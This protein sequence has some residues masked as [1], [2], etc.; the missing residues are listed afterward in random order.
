MTAPKTQ[1]M[2]ERPIGIFDSGLGG[3]SVWREI[4]RQ[5]P[6]ESTIYF[7][8]SAR[9][10]YGPKTPEQV[11]DYSFEITERLLDLGCKAI[12]VACN[13]ATAAAIE[14]LRNSFD[15]PFIGMEPAVKPAALRT[16]TGHVGVLATQGTLKG[17]LYRKTSQKYANDV[18]VHVQIGEG[19]VEL[20]ENRMHESPECEEL[21]RTYIQPMLEAKAD[22]I[23][24]GCTHYPFFKNLVTKISGPHVNIVDPAPA[25]AKQTLNILRKQDSFNTKNISAQ[26]S[27]F[28]TGNLDSLKKMAEPLFSKSPATDV[29]FGKFNISDPTT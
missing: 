2:N 13:T 19:L 28:S 20:V 3:L 1:V 18:L 23:V 29:I 26:H 15:I 7:A 25:V 12:V 16:K 24:L 10:P 17:A 22:H 6:N 8:D 14:E 27:F 4:H 5:A 11:R 9:C 21:L